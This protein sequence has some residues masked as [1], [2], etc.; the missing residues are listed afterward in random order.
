VNSTE[1]LRQ[2]VGHP[3][4]TEVE[5]VELRLVAVRVCN[6]PD[7]IEMAATIIGMSFAC[8]GS[9]DVYPEDAEEILDIVSWSPETAQVVFEFYALMSGQ[10]SEWIAELPP[11][12]LKKLIKAVFEV[13]TD[14]FGQRLPRH[15]KRMRTLATRGASSFSA[16]ASSASPTPTDGFAPSTDSGSA[17]TT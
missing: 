6:L 13:N 14:F 15:W 9:E 4:P 1:S 5:E 17:A 3:K 12:E 8:G 2:L 7:A 10:S 16:P 11:E